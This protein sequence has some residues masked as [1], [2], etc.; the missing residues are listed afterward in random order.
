MRLWHFLLLKHEIDLFLRNRH[1]RNF[2]VSLKRNIVWIGKFATILGNYCKM[3]FSQPAEVSGHAWGES[4]SVP[5]DWGG[6]GHR[7]VSGYHNQG[8]IVTALMI[9]DYKMLKNW[10]MHVFMCSWS[11]FEFSTQSQA[12]IR[13]QLS[14]RHVPALILPISDIPYTVNGKKVTK[15]QNIITW[16]SYLAF[17]KNNDHIINLWMM[18]Q[19]KVFS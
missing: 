1:K 11:N 10:Y 18:H 13:Q 19:F 8:K 17:Q 2:T 6:Q 5:E 4:D 3:S 15:W 16:I 7:G 12:K 9:R 14:A